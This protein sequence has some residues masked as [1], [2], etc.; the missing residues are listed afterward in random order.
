MVVV[1]DR[2]GSWRIFDCRA[3]STVE[4]QDRVTDRRC[5][6]QSRCGGE[7]WYVSQMV[8]PPT[9]WNQS[10]NLSVPRNSPPLRVS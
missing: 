3:T 6:E 2:H 8:V 4:R 7:M 5:G 9:V 10:I 1:F